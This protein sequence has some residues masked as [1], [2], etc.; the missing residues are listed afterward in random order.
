MK[1]AH[2]EGEALSVTWEARQQRL[3]VGRDGGYRRVSLF[4]SPQAA[5]AVD[6]VRRR[7][8]LTLRAWVEDAAA[9][10]MVRLERLPDALFA[11]HIPHDYRSPD[12]AH[13]LLQYGLDE[14]TVRAE[15]LKQEV[16]RIKRQ[17][18]QD[19]PRIAEARRRAD[20]AWNYLA[21]LQSIDADQALR[22]H[23]FRPEADGG[24]GRTLRDNSKR[25]RGQAVTPPPESPAAADPSREPQGSPPPT[26]GAPVA[27]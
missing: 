6:E 7:S 27:P 11:R 15:A 22:E 8:G 16:G 13:E 25:R 19:L 12:L 5:S 24:L 4:L 20:L 2:L 17:H 14:A 21:W 10:D 1:C 23:V 3:K 26:P 18:P 9:R